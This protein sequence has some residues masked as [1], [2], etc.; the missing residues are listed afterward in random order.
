MVEIIEDNEKLI[1]EKENVEKCHNCGSKLEGNE[2]FYRHK[3]P[4]SGYQCSKCGYF[5]LY[6]I[7]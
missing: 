1:A 2:Y 3:A 4:I 7:E 5:K 6:G